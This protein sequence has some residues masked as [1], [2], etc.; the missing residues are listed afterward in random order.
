MRGTG[1]IAASIVCAS[2]GLAA[3][4]S[5]LDKAPFAA[6]P[7]ELL[8]A[9]KGTP[10]D[11]DVAVLRQ[12]FDVA[13]DDKGRA[14]QRWRLVFVVKDQDAV[15]DWAELSATWH[16]SFQDKPVVRAR[17]IDPTGKVEDLDPAQLTDSPTV[18]GARPSDS[19]ELQGPLPHL[20]VGSV[21]E[22]Q[23][24][25]VDR[26]VPPGGGSFVMMQLG[27]WGT[28]IA[29]SRVRLS[30]PDKRKLQ[31]ALRGLPATVRPKRTSS[32]GRTTISYSLGALAPVNGEGWV[33]TDIVTV[34]YIAVAS[35]T[36]WQAA[37]RELRARID[38]AIAGTPLAYPTELP[39]TAS[40]DTVGKVVR[41]LQRTVRYTNTSLY[42]G[43]LLPTPAAET[44][45][46]GYGSELDIAVALVGLLRQAGLKADVALVGT[47]YGT[48]IERDV[49]Q[50]TGFAHALVRVRLPS[51]IWVDPIASDGMP[52]VLSSYQQGK[53]TLIIADD[54]TAP[55]TT[56]LRRA[57]DNLVRE[58]RTYTAAE[59][60]AAR[61]TVVRREGG[62]WERD[63]RAWFHGGKPADIKKGLERSLGELLAVKTIESYKTTDLEDLATPF[64]LTVVA[65]DARR[66][67]TTRDQIDAY[68]FAA[69]ALRML[70][71]MLDTSDTAIQP[72]KQDFWLAS[73]HVYELENRIVVPPGF[74]M[75]VPAAAKKRSLGTMTLTE[76][77]RVDGRTFVVAYR[78]DT[79]KTRLTPKEVTAV[80]EALRA[81]RAEEGLHIVCPNTA[82][83][84]LEHG[85]AQGAIAEIQRLVKLH[86]KEGIHHGQLARAYLGVGAGLAAR[87]EAR[88]GVELEPNEADHQAVLGWVLTHDT[89]GRRYKGDFD[90]AGARAA[91]E[92][93]K[94]L[95][96]KH[97]GAWTELGNLLIRDGN[98]RRFGRGAD[99]A[100]A[101]AAFRASYAL[102]TNA[103]V[104]LEVV[105]SL[106]FSGKAAEAEQFA[107]SMPSAQ[108]RD[109]LL[110]ASVAASRGVPEALR[111]AQTLAVGQARSQLIGMAGGLLFLA[112]Y[113]QPSAQLLLE[114]GLLVPGSP[115]AI[116]LAKVK[117]FDAPLVASSRPEDVAVAL[118]V[119]LVSPGRSRV[120]YWEPAV[121]RELAK[122][123]AAS[124][125]GAKAEAADAM[126]DALLED[127]MRSM[128]VAKV[129]G[130][131]DAWRV[132]LE[133][134]GPHTVVYLA[135]DK[136]VPKVIGASE[137][138]E[139]V[140][141]HVL[142]LLARKDDTAA[143]RVLDWLNK[144]LGGRGPLDLVWGTNLPRTHQAM[145]LAAAVLTDTS[146]FDRTLPLFERCGAT[147]MD[148]QAVC[149]FMAML[150]YRKRKQWSELA[151]HAEDWAKRSP[152]SPM[153]ILARAEAF[154]HLGKLDEADK[155]LADGLVA[156]PDATVLINGQVTVAL[157]RGDAAEAVRRGSKLTARPN[158]PSG[159]HNNLAWLKLVTGAD[160]A[161]ALSDAQKSVQAEP[162][163]PNSLHTLASIEAEL[164]KLVDASK[165]VIAS[166]DGGKEVAPS[167]ATLYVH[168]RILEQLGMTADAIAVYRRIPASTRPSA[169]PDSNELAARRLK[170]LTV[171]H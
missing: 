5:A 16:A 137:A 144:D 44:V 22:E 51:E 62:V 90:R 161:S 71:G 151:D 111:V 123:S 2:F 130:D 98:G 17:V 131:A 163:Q 3:A 94:K 110:L 118:L 170:A 66:V 112:R 42:S 23:I 9:A 77:Q 35:T 21:V 45:K 92:R 152:K 25:T 125:T 103:E 6:T 52:G 97:L 127:V 160:L 108:S 8:A 11:V 141:R 120:A 107:R 37:A 69:D 135:A 157:L 59:N 47:G 145:E 34:P 88:R 140:G 26:E 124:L 87:R 154:A 169:I 102:E 165:H 96:P 139:G 133:Q 116:T 121:S 155:L 61:V 132:E 78:F 54:T 27:M 105:R 81:L 15:Y 93:A 63:Q 149:D 14:T 57:E 38:A 55:T 158:A 147:T 31:I 74:T 85:D 126:T 100:G 156:Q 164:G 83:A 84:L 143:A 167:E 58:V 40:L 33:P 150:A 89:I 48:D 41:W 36:S 1:W 142:R 136:G 168:G 166:A 134:G 115:E 95:E 153:P 148:G 28:P 106:L 64:E 75:P 128:S 79:G 171:K 19:H 122:G 119:T 12:D 53:R 46:R 43:T 109:G 113:Y 159:E 70:P 18:P 146:A 20:A 101:A 50:L 68:F 60:Q 30:S 73:P 10:A 13:F 39:R 29:T 114:A 138:T 104:G 4:E 67:F 56:P 7:A 72:R 82:V 91:F 65:A 117:R 86:P 80:Q 49:P 129:E 99:L 24:T 32:G 162:D 76:E